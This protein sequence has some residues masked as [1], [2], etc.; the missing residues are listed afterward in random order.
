MYFQMR[1]SR[2][3]AE[4]FHGAVVEHHGR[5]DTRVFREV[6][7][8]GAELARLGGATLGRRLASRVAVWFDWESW[9]ASENSSGPSVALDYPAEVWKHYDALH[10]LGY[11]VD[12]V[13]PG[14]DL[15]GHDLLVAPV[16]YLLDPETAAAVRG[17]VAGG[18]TLVTTFLSGVADPSDLV[19]P[20]G[21]P[22]PLRD[23]LGLWVEEIDALPPGEGN[24]IV[25]R[26]RL[27]RLEGAYGCGLLFAILRLD[28]AEAVAEYGEDFYAGTPALTRHRFGRGEAW[29]VASSPEGAFLRGLYAHLAAGRGVAP[30]LADPPPGV[31]ATRRGEGA[32]SVLFVLNHNPHPVVVDIGGEPHRDLLT[33]SA[34]SGE[35]TLAP[36]GVLVAAPAAG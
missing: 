30:V 20:G 10:A 27:G 8:L 5:E 36:H 33:G 19:F 4:K 35:V 9:W 18:G 23:V 25:M 2:G 28:G 22:G 34:A 7:A 24:R 16:L 32:A 15:G 14:S 21:P 29:L 11:Q 1:R 31:E 3:G 12:V 6:A 13:G 26:E 17:F